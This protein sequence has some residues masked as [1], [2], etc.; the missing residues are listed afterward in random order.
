MTLVHPQG[1]EVK[2]VVGAEAKEGGEVDVG[3][4]GQLR[5]LQQ[6]LHRLLWIV[7]KSVL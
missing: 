7:C 4:E 2:G 3:E 6:T 1:A 5:R